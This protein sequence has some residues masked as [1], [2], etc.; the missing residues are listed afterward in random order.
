MLAEASTL[1]SCMKTTLVNSKL[2]VL[3]DALKKRSVY[4]QDVNKGCFALEAVCSLLSQL[5]QKFV[6]W[7]TENENLQH[8]SPVRHLKIASIVSNMYP[9]RIHIA[10]VA[11]VNET[12]RLD[13]RNPPIA[14][15]TKASNDVGQ[16]RLVRRRQV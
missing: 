16:G 12:S 7:S 4:S 9:Y 5:L 11:S 15:Y 8:L 10:H 13:Q 3:P 6:E 2:S 1:N 14:V